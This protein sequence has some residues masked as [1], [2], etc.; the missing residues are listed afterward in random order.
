MVAPYFVPSLIALDH[1]RTWVMGD[2]SL[3]GKIVTDTMAACEPVSVCDK[4]KESRCTQPHL[5]CTVIAC[6]YLNV[7][8]LTVTHLP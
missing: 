8:T 5:P 4:A 6:R 7:N 3:A 1:G 2:A